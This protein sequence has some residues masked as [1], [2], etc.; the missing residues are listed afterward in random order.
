MEQ[1]LPTCTPSIADQRISLKLAG[2]KPNYRHLP[3][4]EPS[5]TCHSITVITIFTTDNYSNQFACKK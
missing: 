4:H 1:S 2:I 5:T 3:G